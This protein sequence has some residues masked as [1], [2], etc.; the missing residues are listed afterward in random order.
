VFH[1]RKTDKRKRKRMTGTAQFTIGAE[2]SC[3]D[4]AVGEVTRVIV[5]PVAEA[6]THLVVGPEHRGDPGRLV[7]LD[8]ID[9]TAGQIR[10]RCTTAEFGKLGAAEETQFIPGT[11][12]YAGYGDGQVSYWPYYG[13]GS[14]GGVGLSGVGMGSMGLGSMGVAGG[15]PSQ[16][17]TY[18]SVPAG[19]VEIRRGDHVQ[20]TDGHIGRVQGL[21]ID[22]GSGHVTHV[23]L[24]EG[25]LWGRREVAIPVSAVASTGDGIQLTITKQEVQD[26]PPVDADH[27]GASAAGGRGT[28]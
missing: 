17:V 9:A 10:L 6:V 12:S 1:D 5:D 3:S 13:M 15:N 19:E 21:V 2:A 16:T 7:P 8:L 24:Q 28:G 25:H 20:A 18:D 4:G 11:G 26:L 14:A 23:L 27:P 22:R